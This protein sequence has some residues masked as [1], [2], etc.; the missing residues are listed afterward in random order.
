MWNVENLK[1]KQIK[2]T[3]IILM[4]INQK[5]KNEECESGKVG[6]EM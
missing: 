6:N 1:S 5:L 3:I 4:Q 2:G